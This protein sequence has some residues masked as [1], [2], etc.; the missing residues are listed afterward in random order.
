[1][2]ILLQ[3]KLNMFTIN[4]LWQNEEYFETAAFDHSATSP[5]AYISTFPVGKRFKT[6]ILSLP[7]ISMYFR[8]ISGNFTTV[9]MQ[10]DRAAQ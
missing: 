5:N 8:I 2:Q 10:I 9:L 4:N 6:L 7:D 3:S 1:M